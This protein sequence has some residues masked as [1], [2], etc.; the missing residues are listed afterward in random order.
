MT[1]LI[2][3]VGKKFTEIILDT[4]KN[5]KKKKE[6]ASKIRAEEKKIIKEKTPEKNREN[7]EIKENNACE[8][9]EKENKKEEK[10]YIKKCP[11]CKN[12]L[13]TDYRNGE[14][15]CKKCGFVIEDA[16]V[17]KGPEWR[18][19]DEDQVVKKVR[20]GSAI[21]FTKQDKGLVTEI[22]RHD[23]DIKGGAVL[24]Q[25]KALLYRLRKWQRRSRVA[26]SNDRNLSLALPELDRMCTQ[27]H[28]SRS[29]Q[30][31]CAYF[32][33]KAT[34]KGLTK[35]KG[36]ESMVAATIFLVCKKHK[37]PQTLS[38]LR[39]VANVK[40]RDIGRCTAILKEMDKNDESLIF[41][42]NNVPGKDNKKLL[43]FLR[44]ELN[45]KLKKKS[46]IEKTEDNSITIENDVPLNLK[47]DKEKNTMVLETGE[48]ICEFIVK[49]ENNELNVYLKS[50][51]V[52][53]IRE[54]QTPVIH[55]EDYVPQFA[56]R[57]MIPVTIEMEAIKI[58]KEARSRGITVGKSPV[59]FAVAAIFLVCEKNK[60]PINLSSLNDVGYVTI[61][62][63]Y[64]ELKD[65]LKDLI[66]LS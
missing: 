42:L 30:E 53:K 20:T 52:K 64:C 56:E 8:V 55:A 24:P 63:K 65:G 15:Y 21:R 19:F 17:D 47:F 6:S 51:P 23:R 2:K 36:T 9:I 60:I 28:M 58:L 43:D 16:M 5:R 54:T 46:K 27:L 37:K 48:K 26:E 13:I 44:K 4:E 22:D 45:I 41:C 50:P 57:L 49:E 35:G 18:A 14:I 33:R 34:S 29:I 40:R 62:K 10:E 66:S 1:E 61:R 3:K 32:Y 31:D 11:E 25:R 59:G 38:N 39:R 7:K 12:D